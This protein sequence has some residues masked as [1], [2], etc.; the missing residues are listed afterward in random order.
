V[1]SIYIKIEKVAV[2]FMYKKKVFLVITAYLVLAFLITCYLIENLAKNMRDYLMQENKREILFSINYV[3]SILESNLLQLQTIA[4][5]IALHYPNFTFMEKDFL[6]TSNDFLKTK[7]ITLADQEGKIILS[8]KKEIIGKNI[9]NKKY[10]SYVLDKGKCYISDQDKCPVTSEHF[11]FLSVP[12][13]KNGQV[14]AVLSSAV[15]SDWLQQAM[16]KA[17]LKHSQN[18]IVTLI[19][20]KGTIIYSSQ[21]KLILKNVNTSPVVTKLLHDSSG[22]EELYAPFLKEYRYFTY[23]PLQKAHWGI[24]IS[25]PSR[26]VYKMIIEVIGT[27][28]LVLIIFLLPLFSLLYFLFQSE[29]LRYSQLTQMQKDKARTVNEM[30]ASVAHEIRNPLT[31]IRGFIQLLSRNNLT[32][33]AQ[34]YINVIIEEI[35]RLESIIG[36]FLSFSSLRETKQS[37]CDLKQILQFTYFLAE[38][39]G[40]YN[41]V[42]VVFDAPESIFI[43]GDASELKQAFINFSLNAIQAMPQGGKLFI[44]LQQR[45]SKAVVSFT[46]TGY[47]M[48][49]KTISKLGERYFT[50]KK[51]GT[52]L[53]LAVSYR[54]LKAHKA[55]VVVISQ[56]NKGTTF[57]IEFFILEKKDKK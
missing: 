54:I 51:E 36:Q 39:R 15:N 5:T 17:V 4:K 41:K 42:K 10:F 6:T 20:G 14:I 26:Y 27:L 22:T 31:S 57:Q 28:L 48:D 32:V 2:N 50:T 55:K 35:D 47:G 49:E 21:K 13:V 38:G 56:I 16:S 46:D 7:V 34:S 23:A 37:I 43:L 44:Q 18:F 33:K 11:F 9:K 3:D 45:G 25:Q 8:N 52:G 40:C 53:G 19:D 29:K 12:V 30:A 24:I 1:E